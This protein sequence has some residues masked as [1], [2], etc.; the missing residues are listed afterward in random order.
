MSQT[1]GGETLARKA[2]LD[3]AE[4]FRKDDKTWGGNVA[5]PHTTINNGGGQGGNFKGIKLIP[6]DADADGYVWDLSGLS[7]KPKWT[8]TLKVKGADG[9]Y[10]D[11]NL[12]N[13]DVIQIH[14]GN[15]QA[16]MTVQGKPKGDPAGSPSINVTVPTVAR[17]VMTDLKGRKTGL[18]GWDSP[19]SGEFGATVEPPTKQQPVSTT[20]NKTWRP[21]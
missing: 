12:E 6:R 1:G 2:A 4:K 14:S 10:T 17:S 9:N 3:Y 7:R 16:W 21:K 8:G 5:Q 18:D 11:L 15:G 19:E 13:A 20:P